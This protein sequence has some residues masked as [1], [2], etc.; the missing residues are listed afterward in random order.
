MFS[1]SAGNQELLLCRQTL[2]DLFDVWAE[3][4]LCQ[5]MDKT[6]SNLI[7]F[8]IRTS[9]FRFSVHSQQSTN[10]TGILL[11]GVLLPHLSLSRR[12]WG[13]CLHI[14]MPHSPRKSHIVLWLFPETVKKRKQTLLWLCGCVPNYG[15]PPNPM[16]VPPYALYLPGSSQL[17]KEKAGREPLVCFRQNDR[18]CTEEQGTHRVGS[19]YSADNR[20]TRGNGMTH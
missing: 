11:L 10:I 8:I 3:P 6:W 14:H 5:I 19:T 20:R 15:H 9:L 13:K 4:E 18:S 12:M 1:C 2:A 7:S 17:F 16:C